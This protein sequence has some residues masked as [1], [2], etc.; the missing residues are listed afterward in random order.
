MSEKP[1]YSAVITNRGFR[2]LWLNQI[3]VQ[4]AY[5]TLNFALII[6]VFKLTNSNFAV[7][8]LMLSVY[9]P[10]VIFG[11]FAGVFVDRADRRR[12][13][14]LVD[15]L[16]ALTFFVFIFI[17]GSY[18]LILLNAFIINSLAQFFIPAESSSIPLLVPRKLLFI[19]NSLFS[20]TLYASFMIGF[21][22]GGPILSSFGINALFIT[23]AGIL[24][25][26]F[27]LARNLPAITTSGFREDNGRLFA[28]AGIEK[29]ARLT[30]KE[31]RETLGYIKGK[32]NIIAAIALMSSIQGVIA[33]MAVTM[34]SYL[35]RVLHIHATDSSYFMMLPL[36][37]GMISG[38]LIVGRLFYGRPKR[39]IVLPAV[40]GG[41]LLLILVGLLPG[42][43][44]IVHSPE[45]PLYLA[46]PRYFTRALNLASL[47]A[48]ISYIA[49]F[50]A[51]SVIIPCQTLIQESTT[52]Q[53]RGKIFSTM[54][55]IMTATSAVAAV[56]AGALSDIIGVA[57]FMAGLGIIVTLAA[58][59]AIWPQ[60][61]LSRKHLPVRLL[62]FLGLGHWDEDRSGKSLVI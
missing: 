41:G 21:T 29:M 34:P 16:L 7:S 52:E 30:V 35:E 47:F 13:I 59:I 26:A 3:M 8:L 1:S 20:L 39:K 4:L 45:L 62:E 58:L 28:L 10:S 12:I 36:G 23:G 61:F 50:C 49:G 56:F 17:K 44:A 46:R 15:F 32:L 53:N 60:V 57:E 6:W 14:L 5:N 19:A 42:L 22:M 51:V 38:A 27:L 2:F 37:L 40:L 25:F 24:I 48:V 54:A 43:A 31:G 55:V 18:H 33:I 9:L 11:I